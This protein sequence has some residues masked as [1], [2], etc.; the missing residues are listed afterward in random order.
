MPTHTD[1]PTQADVASL[2][3][4]PARTCASLYLPTSNLPTEAEANRIEYKNLAHTAVERLTASGADKHEVHAIAEAFDELE[5]DEDFWRLQARSLA[6]FATADGLRAFR[7][8]NNLSS[9]VEVADRFF[10]KPLLRTVAFPQA[11]FVLALSVNGVRLLQ[12][13]PEPPAKL[14]SVP[15]MPADALSAV[16]RTSLKDNAPT[17]RTQGDAGRKLRLRQY[18]RRVE[19]ALRPIL[20]GRNLPLI[21]AATEPLESIYRATTTY[22]GLANLVIEGNPDEIPDEQ[23]DQRARKV[24][25]DVYAHQVAEIA[26]L[27]EVRANDDRATS[28]LARVARAAT[29]GAVD[30]LLVDIDVMISGTVDTDTGELE[31]DETDT[32]S[33]YGVVD[34]IAKRVMLSGGKVLA[35]RQQEIPGGSS[36]AA[37]LRYPV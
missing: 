25:D 23:L 16:G 1:I 15:N 9:A 36:A 31:L 18:A 8:P 19:S 24:L 28:D 27:Y 21:L 20:S 34:E 3:S 12:I 35:V 5:H 32:V 7:L 2:M 11:A 14:V 30:T 37:I 33:N 13:S 4:S 29:F 26:E 6:V 10:V 17:S 22:P